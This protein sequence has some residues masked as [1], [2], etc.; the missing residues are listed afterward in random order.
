MTHKELARA[1][2]RLD[3]AGTPADRYALRTMLADRLRG[4][5]RLYGARLHALEADYQRFL[6][7]WTTEHVPPGAIPTRLP[8]DVHA[9]RRY[10]IGGLVALTAESL[11]AA[12]IF[13]HR[14]VLP[15]FGIVAAVCVT[16]VFDGALDLLLVAKNPR[17]KEALRTLKRRLVLPAFLAFVL[18]AAFLALA[19]YVEGGLALL[20][21]PLFSGALWVA[22]MAL[23]L[24]AAALF[25][26]AHLYGTTLRQEREYAELDREA[27]QNFAFLRELEREGPLV[28]VKA[29]SPDGDA[30]GSSRSA[31]QSARGINAALL[32]LA[33]VGALTSCQPSHGSTAAETAA[34]RPERSRCDVVLDLSG[35]V[36]GLARVWS[37]VRD[38]LPAIITGAHCRELAVSGFDTDG[39]ML[40]PLVRPLEL[41]AP[42]TPADAGE[43]AAFGNFEQAAAADGQARYAAT[44]RDTLRVLD[45]VQLPDSGVGAKGSDVVGV[46]QRFAALRDPEPRL[47]LLLTDFADSRYRVI[48]PIPAPTGAIRL[49]VLLAPARPKD[50]RLAIG[51]E[52]SAA[53]QYENRS[54]ELKRAAP[55]VIVVPYFTENLADVVAETTTVSARSPTGRTPR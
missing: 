30:H 40:R 52:L 49:I 50:A 42:A 5:L 47:V 25:C 13:A 15:L 34:A 51:R 22:T 7:S 16:L 24:L 38:E 46:V 45:G 27:R 1:A 6:S 41:P 39:W 36:V 37:H 23:L 19:R 54:R 18:A 44:V 14:G 43:W 53:D 28:E 35:S 10:L 3:D 48:P 33:A 26:A 2:V 4:D 12:W 20:L 11:L 21:L 17:P 8:E 9:R 31:F 55:W 32:L 29:G